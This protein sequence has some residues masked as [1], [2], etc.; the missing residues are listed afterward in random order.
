MPS[1]H[2]DGDGYCG[3]A[4]DRDAVTSAD[5]CAT[6][7]KLGKHASFRNMNRFAFRATRRSSAS[8]CPGEMVDFTVR[9]KD[10]RT[11]AQAFFQQPAPLRS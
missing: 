5:I 9:M 11:F 10:G 8:R 4:G 1:P 2:D 6:R 3:R 7:S